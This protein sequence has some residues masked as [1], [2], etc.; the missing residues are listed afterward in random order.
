MIDSDVHDAL[1]TTDAETG[2]LLVAGSSG[3][4]E[5][6]RAELLAAHGARVRAV[7][8][9]GGEG[10]RPVPHEVPI[11][12]F[13]EHL[14]L[15]RQD[16]DRVAMF[17]TSFGAEATLLTAT[18][19]PIDVTIAVAPS[20]VVWPGILDGEWSS[21]LAVGG[22]P[23]A[24]VPFDSAWTATTDPPEYVGLYEASLARDEARATAASIPVERIEGD[25]L[26]VAGG[27]DR[28]WPSVDFAHRIDARRAAHGK[29]TRVITHPDAGHRLL[30]PG[31]QVTTGGMRMIRG[32][33]PAADAELGRCAWDALAAL[34]RLDV[35]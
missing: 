28:V 3:R 20:S 33:S 26:L 23:V 5:R 27:D 16:H 13:L 29:T 7:R 10:Q 32:G 15:L 18:M 12:F 17:G 8:W 19:T 22:S 11:E 6:E 31:E 34:L 1:P 35:H 25:L 21:H 4:V 30:L 2:V 9:F 14:E 24:Y